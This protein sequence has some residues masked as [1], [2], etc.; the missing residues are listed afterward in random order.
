M[1]NKADPEVKS[2]VRALEILELLARA[3]R[4]LTLK[5]IVS[6]LGYPKSSTYNLLAT[7]VSR[8]YVIREEPESYRIHEAFR[9]GPGWTSGRE[10]QLIATAQPIMDALR[11]AEHETV[12][13]GSRRRD[14][15]VKL[16]AKSVSHQLVRFDSDLTG[17]D[18]AF[19]TAMGRVLL[20]YWNPEK[21]SAYLAR[22]RIVQIT[23]HT[24]IDRV[25]IRKIIEAARQDGYA[26]SDE[27]AVAGGSGVAA[28]VRDASGTVIAALNIATVTAR[29]DASRERMIAA[30]IRYADELSARLGYKS[31]DTEN[32]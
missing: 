18:A 11:D 27:E 13:L 4:P 17:S 14:G 20:A 12:F 30:V 23:E 19:C 22:E 24:V 15:R 7:L 3:R 6:E 28:P 10:A 32:R 5:N 26:I 2:A 31:Q 29:F 21:T 1:N 8:A 9:N 25:Q 16:L